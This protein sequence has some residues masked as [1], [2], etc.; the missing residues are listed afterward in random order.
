MIKW[1][2]FIGMV[3]HVAYTCELHMVFYVLPI[4]LTRD[5]ALTTM[6]PL[7]FY[8]IGQIPL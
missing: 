1:K 2:Y 3:G 7:I 8:W 5:V 6:I 4:S